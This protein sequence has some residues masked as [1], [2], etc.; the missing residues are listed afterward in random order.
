MTQNLHLYLFRGENPVIKVRC[1]AF[2]LEREIYTPF[3]T[4]T[5]E[6]LSDGSDYSDIDRIALYLDNT[7]IFLGLADSVQQFHKLHASFVRISSRSFPSLLTQ[8]ELEPGLHSN[9]TISSLMTGFYQFPYLTY[10]NLPDSGYIFVKSGN[11]MWDG[12]VSFGYKITGHYPYA[13]QNHICLS[14]PQNQPHTDFS[15]S[16]ILEYGTHIETSRLISHYHM[17]GFDGTPNTYQQENPA[18]AAFHIV[19]HKQIPFDSSFRHDP[20]DALTFRNLFS[21]R[22]SAS[23]YLLYN[24]FR[25]EQL[26]QTISFGSLI[27]NETV[28]RVHCTFGTNGFRTKLFCYHD[29]FYN[30][31]S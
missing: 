14:P 6:F 20:Q 24:G 12:V 29:G 21:R 22:S 16:Q 7:C 15:S 3:E 31:N 5:A 27:Q 28:C 19:R 1:L 30:L 25:N 18:A 26:G 23:S 10:E 2:S 13:V 11:T 17:E 9:L 8:N 4:V